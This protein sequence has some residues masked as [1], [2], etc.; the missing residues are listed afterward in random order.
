MCVS[1][2]LLANLGAKLAPPRTPA[3]CTTPAKLCSV[4]ALSARLEVAPGLWPATRRGRCEQGRR[5]R[6]WDERHN[7][8]QPM[9][10]A[11]LAKQGCQ[12]RCIGVHAT[13]PQKLIRLQFDFK[14]PWQWALKGRGARCGLECNPPGTEMSRA[15]CPVTWMACSS[16]A[17]WLS[18]T[19]AA[20]ESC[21]RAA[22]CWG[23]AAPW[24]ART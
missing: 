4:A 6:S 1:S 14:R 19:L 15:G 8:S 16:S 2:S 18:C 11:H 22:S 13:R 20:G 9:H 24:W 5:C 3:C 23:M 10:I 21:G 12:L 17:T 7:G